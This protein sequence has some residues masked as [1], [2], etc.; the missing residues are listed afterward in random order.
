M[1]MLAGCLN[2]LRLHLSEIEIEIAH[3]IVKEERDQ[4]TTYKS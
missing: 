1:V 3:L 2:N 4:A